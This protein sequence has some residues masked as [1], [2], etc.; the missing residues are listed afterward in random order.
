MR[1]IFLGNGPFAA[2]ALRACAAAGLDIPL[3]VTRPDRP[4]GKHQVVVPGPVTALANELELPLRQ[5]ESINDP[6]VLEELKRQAADLLVVA[7]YGQIL[8][9]EAL[10]TTRLGGINIHGSLL[11]KYRGAAPIV[12]AVY[13]GEP[14]TGVS[15]IQ[16]TAGLDAGGVILQ[17][18]IPIGPE[19][20]AG[21][22][23]PILA[24]L[25]AKLAIEAVDLLASGKAVAIPQDKLQVTKAPRV[26]KE[27][28]MIDW[29]RSAEDIQNQIRAMQPWPIAYTQWKR[30]KGEPMRIQILRSRVVIEESAK[31]PGT[32]LRLGPA[33]IAIATGKGTLEIESIRP[34]G[35][36]ALD[37]AA[38]L[39][40][41]RLAVGQKLGD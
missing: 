18:E 31:S 38:F 16:M 41:N 12:W 23:E 7:D 29:A 4:Q 34:A 1:I 15:I 27:D 19:Q 10:Q 13:H 21:D 11:P 36:G 28:G 8:S 32:I 25:G 35:K 9:R 39:R 26:R 2:P 3:V 6:T 40:G 5:P 37:V 33:A 17:G 24:E 14:S 22:I 20:T 30:D